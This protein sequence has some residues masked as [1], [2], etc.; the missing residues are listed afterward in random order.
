MRISTQN[1]ACFQRH[2]NIHII[3]YYAYRHERVSEILYMRIS[4]QNI[5]CFQRQRHNNI[6]IIYNYAYRHE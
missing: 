5:A 1:I 4:T 3:Y 2:N 6:H